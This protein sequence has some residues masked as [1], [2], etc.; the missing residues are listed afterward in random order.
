MS[1]LARRNRF[2]PNRGA[3]SD[4]RLASDVFIIPRLFANQHNWR[5]L[6]SLAKDSLRR[7]LVK[8]ARRTFARSSANF[9]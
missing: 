9:A 5:I 7:V 6:G 3:P 8:V 1:E 2:F 4:K